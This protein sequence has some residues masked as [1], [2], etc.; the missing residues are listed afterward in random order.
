MAIWGK[1]P[2]KS[3][4]IGKDPVAG[5]DWGQ[6]KRETEDEMVGWHHRLNG[7]EFGQTLGDSEGQGSLACCSSWG[8]KESD[9]T[10]QLTNNNLLSSPLPQL[11]RHQAGIGSRKNRAYFRKILSCGSLIWNSI[12]FYLGENGYMYMM[13][14]SLCCSPE[15][16]SILLIGCT[17]IWNKMFKVRGKKK[18][19]EMPESW[20]SFSGSYRSHKR[21]DLKF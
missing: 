10:L 9:T 19:K 4:L 20:K 8:Q 18:E 5:K 21:G 13:A 2:R 16:T 17:P 14:E 12:S 6:K 3:Q 7:H 15:A 1:E 11:I